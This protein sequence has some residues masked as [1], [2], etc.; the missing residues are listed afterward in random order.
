MPASVAS[1]IGRTHTSPGCGTTTRP[2]LRFWA[3]PSNIA[4]ASVETKHAGPVTSTATP[5][6]LPASS[7]PFL[8]TWVKSF[9]PCSTYPIRT[10]PA[11]SP[12][13]PGVPPAVLPDGPAGARFPQPPC[14]SGERSRSERSERRSIGRILVGTRKGERAKT[15]KEWKEQDAQDREDAREGNALQILF[16]LS[17]L[18]QLFL[19]S[20]FRPFALSRPKPLRSSSTKV[21]PGCGA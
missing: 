11:L 18:F 4:I 21:S 19:L 6:A 12:A 14:A 16:T 1:L 15:R 10:P 8:I 2:S 7:A 13:P 17:S 5:S 9:R 20:R 3:M